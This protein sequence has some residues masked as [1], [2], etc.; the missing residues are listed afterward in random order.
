MEI[1]AGVGR[2]DWPV[3]VKLFE[4]QAMS[5]T[6]KSRQIRLKTALPEDVLAFKS[7]RMTEGLSR[8]F[9]MNLE[10]YSDSPS[11][12]FDDVLGHNLTV[13]LDT[14]S[15]AKERFFNGFVSRFAFAGSHGRRY[16]YQAV[17]SPW[18]WFLTRAQNCRIFHDQD[19][20]AIIKA[21]FSDHSFQ[22]YKFD[23][24][25]SYPKYEYCVQYNETDFAFISRLLEREGVYFYY[26]HE[27]G[28]HEMVI[29]DGK[30]G[31][32]TTGGYE[33]M[34]YFARDAF[35]EGGRRE[36]VFGWRPESMVQTTSFVTR[37]YNFTNPRGDMNA[38]SAIARNHAVAE[39]EVYEYPGRFS[40]KGEG[41]AYAKSRI[42]ELQAR[43]TIVQAE[44]NVRAVKSGRIFTLTSHPVKDFNAEYL[45]TSAVHVLTADDYESGADSE[46]TYRC[47]FTA[48]E[49]K[50]PFRSPR[51][52][53]KPKIAGPQTAVVV[54]KKGEEIDPD[55]HGRV[56]VQ[57][58]WER[59]AA[60]NAYSCWT[61]VSQSW[62]GT[63]WGGM[64][65]PRI[66]QEVIVEF[67]DGDPD[68]PLIT[69]RV[70]NA[71]QKPP[72]PLPDNSHYTL[73][74]TNTLKG[75]GF[76][77]LRFDDTAGKEG[78]FVHAQH[79]YDRRVLHD[80]RDIVL[81]E[82]HEIV[83]KKE[84]REVHE[85][86]HETLNANSHLSVA[87]T[88][89]MKMGSDLLIKTGDNMVGTVGSQLH[90]KVGTTAV[91]EAGTGL[92]LK[93]GGSFITIDSAGVHIKGPIVNINSGGSALSGLGTVP[94]KADLPE[95]ALDTKGG[96]K[97]APT[98]ARQKPP[99]P[100][101][102]DSHPVAAALRRAAAS[103]APFC[104]ICN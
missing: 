46:E 33:K 18:T 47:S 88:Y 74:R 93:V 36:C 83:K 54:G 32:T 70:Y 9:E 12:N 23:L 7:M 27:N 10:F 63:E 96:E 6:Q 95:E 53:P 56:K 67:E 43:Q 40:A 5:L 91:I 90:Y 101:E 78:I 50:Y 29:T 16:V 45:I 26:I 69:G 55:A 71:M 86:R 11:I 73:F 51:L 2:Q 19:M 87:E 61:R 80:S 15:G 82:Q 28:R 39:L 14:H 24:T 49:T 13:G 79:D 97:D 103:G 104:E 99:T 81:N 89:H 64:S 60:P 65:I 85:D 37:D 100:S 30:A 20:E 84:F 72:Y 59:H 17:A 8:L 1:P 48:L 35:S 94:V 41:E 21:V 75:Q 66:G 25:K 4:R 34:E 68:R 102:L 77:E 92:T 22:D 57:F 52:T 58:S 42:E 98:A 3:A 38:E 31:H 76:N 62:A 44:G